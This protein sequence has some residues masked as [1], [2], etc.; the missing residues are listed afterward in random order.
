MSLEINSLIINICRKS[1]MHKYFL[2]L[3]FKRQLMTDPLCIKWSEYVCKNWAS[4]PESQISMLTDTFITKTGH[5]IDE[6]LSK[7]TQIH[8]VYFRVTCTFLYGLF[9]MFACNFS[10]YCFCGDVIL[11][12][13]IWDELWNLLYHL[14]TR[15]I[16]DTELF[17]VVYF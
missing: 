16:F 8:Y 13:S 14:V 3:F 7:E 12:Q 10:I 9:K 1:L 4:W 6:E 11:L 17:V 2:N 5:S 15:I